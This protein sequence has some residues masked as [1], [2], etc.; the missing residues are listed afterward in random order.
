MDEYVECV[1]VGGC[2][3]TGANKFPAITG[4]HGFALAL[5]KD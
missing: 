4:F 1:C 3:F 5:Y 2:V